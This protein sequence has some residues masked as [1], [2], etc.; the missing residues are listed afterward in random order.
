MNLLQVKWDLWRRVGTLYVSPTCGFPC[1]L[2]AWQTGLTK[3]RYPLMVKFGQ[4][5]PP[6]PNRAPKVGGSEGRTIRLQDL[7]VGLISGLVVASLSVWAQAGLDDRRSEREMAAAELSAAEAD[8]REN[9]RFVRERSSSVAEP[10]PFQ[11]MDLRYENLSGL[12]LEQ[13]DFEGAHMTGALATMTDVR[14]ADMSFVTATGADFRQANLHAAK[15]QFADLSG[16]D[17]S[18]ADLSQADLTA[19]DLAGARLQGADLT[20]A[21]LYSTGFGPQRKITG[22]RTGTACYD[23]ETI[24]PADFT[25]PVMDPE[26]CPDGRASP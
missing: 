15:L 1:E 20:D 14:L 7:F 9:L 19:A 17:L 23:S 21:I 2:P 5:F 13:A 24:W 8:R 16:S 26:D 10:R 11:G 25:P 4:S 6:V 18:G 3:C 12:A 22:E